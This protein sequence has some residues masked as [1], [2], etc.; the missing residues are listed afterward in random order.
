[1]KVV[2]AQTNP[3]VGA[4]GRN[5]EQIVEMI[6][7]SESAGADLVVF[8]ELAVFGY[9]PKDLL[10]REEMIRDNL[11]AL[12][13]IAQAC[14]QT[15]AIV[16]YVQPVPDQS[17]KGIYNAAAV[18]REGKVVTWYA[19]R[20]L[21]TYDVFDEARYFS[22]GD[23]TCVVP[24]P[25]GQDGRPLKVGLTIC[26]D[27]W[28]DAQ[29]GG[30]PV[31]GLDPLTET[32]RDGAEWIVNVGA[33]PFVAGKQNLRT[34]IFGSQV[35][36]LNV[37][38]ISVN[39]VGGNDDLLF[40][41]ASFLLDGT[42][43]VLAQ[44][45]AFEESLLT[46]DVENPTSSDVTPY[47]DR[48]ESI[49]LGLAT[50]IRDY[51]HKCGFKQALVGLSGGIDSAVTAA[52]A[53]DALGAGNVFGVA[54]PS[55][56][57][58]DHS[59]EDATTLAERLGIH[60]DLISIENI[61]NIFE[62]VM[63][64][65]FEGFEEDITEE[66]MQARIRG[67]ILMALSNK[68]GRLLLTTGNKSEMAVGYCTLYGDMCGGLSVLS[69]VPKTTVYELATHINER[70]GRPL[71]P[72]RTINKPPSAELREDQ[73]DSDSLP[74]YELLDT[75]LQHYV[76]ED[77]SVSRMI[78]AGLPAATVQQIVRLVDRNEYKRQQAAI[79]IKVT[80]RAFGSG[81]RMPVAARY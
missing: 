35:T 54:M 10:M 58:S 53:A 55:R 50:G 78:D 57:S 39:Q 74:P 67:V 8:P 47:P 64:P 73:Q 68:H 32:V 40:D 12:D 9:P 38:L 69:D 23:R 16:G 17:G 63:K 51:L 70:A 49:R 81:R 56:F 7:A 33:S 15:T 19:K 72:E 75:I 6:A 2:L 22:S 30:R 1:M 5:A 36:R 25:V 79:G 71:I 37:P 52:I 45:P 11:E 3:L 59:I 26:E 28:N 42:G 4:I 27:I 46:V 20:L 62:N 41:G 21:P 24:L 60:F 14:T 13:R 44:A 29:F 80:S 18:C 66:N 48:L 31:Y 76:E 61:H 65:H 43:K 77:W 34:E